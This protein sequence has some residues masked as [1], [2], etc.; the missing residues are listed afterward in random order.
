LRILASTSLVL[1]A[2]VLTSPA[3]A[4]TKDDRKNLAL[5]ADVLVTAPVEALADGSGPLVGA[6]LRGGVYA[7]PDIEVSL[8]V[9]YQRGLNKEVGS[10]LGA[11]ITHALDDL[12]LLVGARAYVLQPR[13]GLYADV[14]I[15]PR[16]LSLRSYTVAT[17]EASSETLLR[18]GGN[19]GVGYLISKAIPID[20]GVQLAVFNLAGRSRFEGV[21][22][23]VTTHLG[24]KARF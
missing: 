14:E 20:I 22:L 5:G 1:L 24:Y 2:L 21:A 13:A 8:R 10:F 19:V 9:G 23:G 7:A 6:S 11:P 3:S 12:A 15:G 4:D 16:L 18:G 17:A